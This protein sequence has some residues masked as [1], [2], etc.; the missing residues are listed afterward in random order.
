MTKSLMYSL[1]RELNK[2]Q[3][4]K[5]FGKTL[6]LIGHTMR[7]PANNITRKLFYWNPQEKRKIEIPKAQRDKN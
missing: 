3:Q 6:N 4:L 7:K 2:F 1:W 5:R